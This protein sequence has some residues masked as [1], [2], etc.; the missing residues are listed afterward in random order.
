[1]KEELRT[2]YY[3][4]VNKQRA[5]IPPDLLKTKIPYDMRQGISGLYFF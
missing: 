1:M 3:F 2:D 4:F 5:I